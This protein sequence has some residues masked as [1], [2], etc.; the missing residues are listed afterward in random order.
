MNKKFDYS[1]YREI[2]LEFVNVGRKKREKPEKE[3][4]GRGK[5]VYLYV[6]ISETK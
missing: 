4:T 3:G 5:Q 2:Y 6:N 1:H